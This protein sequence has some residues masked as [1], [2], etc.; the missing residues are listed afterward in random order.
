MGKVLTQPIKNILCKFTYKASKVS[1]H[2]KESKSHTLVG[3]RI[4]KIMFV[5]WDIYLTIKMHNMDFYM[6][7]IL[8]YFWG[9]KQLV[10]ILSE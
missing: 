5:S 1:T 10:M 4:E 8:H 9:K 7:S 3:E 2:F 6:F